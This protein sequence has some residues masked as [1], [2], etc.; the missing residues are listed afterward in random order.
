MF[1]DD[2]ARLAGRVSGDWTAAYAS[3]Y[4]QAAEA[5][6]V[7]QC[8]RR[9]L[10]VACS[11]SRTRTWRIIWAILD[12]SANDVIVSFGL[13]QFMSLRKTPSA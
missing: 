10:W 9:A 4:C 2:G 11:A 8:H 13:M 3:A 6:V 7:V 1:F 5:I 12:T